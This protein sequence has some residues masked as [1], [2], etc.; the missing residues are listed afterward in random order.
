VRIIY[1]GAK[2]P[3]R[4]RDDFFRIKVEASGAVLLDLQAHMIGR[5]ARVR[6]N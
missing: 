4:S 1:A 2:I 3:L 6:V 5:V